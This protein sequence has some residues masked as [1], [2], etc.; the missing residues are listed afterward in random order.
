MKLS[1][2]MYM[3]LIIVLYTYLVVFKFYRNADL[4]FLMYDDKFYM[5][6]MV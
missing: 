5:T 2:K 6:T 3:A 1:L 4:A